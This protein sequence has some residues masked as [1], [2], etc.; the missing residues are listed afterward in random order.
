MKMKITD[1]EFNINTIIGVQKGRIPPSTPNCNGRHSDCFVY[2][3][4]G[5]AD[6]IFDGKNFKAEAGN[7]I[8][9]AEGSRYSIKVNDEN[10]TFIFID[11]FFEKS[12]NR[13]F[14]NEIYKQKSLSLLKS[15]FEKILNLWKTGDYSDKIYCKSLI[16][17]IYSEIA[18]ANFSKYVS[19]NRREQIENIVDY[20]TDNIGEVNLDISKLSKMCNISE[21]HFRRIFSCIYRVSPKRFITIVRVNSAKELLVSE[22]LSIAEISKS[23]GFENQYYFS[24]VFKSETNMTPSQYRK[25]YKNI[26]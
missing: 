20:I 15:N 8:F 24:K 17:K 7:V 26:L 22:N 4:S 11:F 23:C 14:S 1:M 5:E 18:K 16:Y 6:Y 12:E 10:Y 2:V 3:L 19:L 9:L 21:V 25:F 13:S